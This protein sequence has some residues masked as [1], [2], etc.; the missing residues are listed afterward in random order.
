MRTPPV[1]PVEEFSETALLLKPV[2]RRTQVDPFVLHGPPKPFDKDVVVAASAPIHADLY[3]MI[4]QYPREH[5]AG[6]LLTLK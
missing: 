3:P 2:G 1:V 4:Q 5:L 6:E